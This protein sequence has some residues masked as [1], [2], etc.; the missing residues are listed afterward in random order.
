MIRP[1]VPKTLR[2]SHSL[3]K[4]RV[5]KLSDII[6][7]LDCQRTDEIIEMFIDDSSKNFIFREDNLAE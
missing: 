2:K 3:E 5:K 7:Q 6:R 1:A 4:A